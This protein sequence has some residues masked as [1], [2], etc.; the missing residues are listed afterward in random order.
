MVAGDAP[1]FYFGDTEYHVD[2]SD[3]Y[4]E[5]RVWRTG[6]DLSKMGTVTVRSRKTDPVSAEGLEFQAMNSHL[7]FTPDSI[8]CL[9]S[10]FVRRYWQPKISRV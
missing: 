2:E 9:G 8:Y 7:L 3:G 1:V 4:V 6:S 5:V 10:V